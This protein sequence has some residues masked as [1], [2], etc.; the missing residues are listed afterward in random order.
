MWNILLTLLISLASATMYRMGGSGR[1]PRQ[2]RVV[3][4]P[5]LT[6]LLAF[7]TGVHSWW[8]LLSIPIT[9]GAISTYWDFL[10]PKEKNFDNFW[11]HGFFIGLAAFPI[12]IA[13][14]HWWMFAVRCV[15]L[16]VIIGSWSAIWKW[17]VAEEAGRGFAIPATIWMIC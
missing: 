6:A 11:L 17:D 1:Y 9:I 5:C 4:V 7:L 13:T 2:V 12:A 8:V 10:Y 15:L 3:G 16:A 14:G